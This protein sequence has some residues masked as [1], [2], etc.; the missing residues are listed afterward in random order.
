M[1][2]L[3]AHTPAEDETAIA[4][5]D[6]RLGN[7]IFHPTEPRVLAVLDWELST[8]GHPLADLAYNCIPW[9][10]PAA[11]EGLQGGG[12][13]GDSGRGAYVAAY[14]RRDRAGRGADAGFLRGVLAVP[15]GGDRGGRL[16][17]GAGRQCGGCR[18][19]AIGN[20]FRV[21]AEAAWTLAERLG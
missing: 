2:W 3:P 20:K 6:F 14:C 13:A 15:L 10:L 19:M 4:H 11:I 18:G 9:R 7:L 5:G 16:P 1:A 8:L 21:L 17:P 12:R